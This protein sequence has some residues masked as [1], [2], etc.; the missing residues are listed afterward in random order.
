MASP[1]VDEKVL[2]IKRHPVA[3]GLLG[4]WRRS[5][6]MS[7]LNEQVLF[8][9]FS[10]IAQ[11]LAALVA[12]SAMVAFYVLSQSRAVLWRARDQ[13]VDWSRTTFPG[14]PRGTSHEFRDIFRNRLISP[15]EMQSA[16][17]GL[18]DTVIDPSDKPSYELVLRDI[19]RAI[20]RIR[21]VHRG[22]KLWVSCGA[23]AICLSLL[24]LPFVSLVAQSGWRIFFLIWLTLVLLVALATVIGVAM[25]FI[26]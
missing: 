14:V 23:V 7:F 5:K 22:L 13:L 18:L 20:Y 1:Y 2:E 16:L 9:T 3:A 15:T 6:G 10:T 19:E 11:A 12:L 21:M 26:Q 17:R 25:Q 8:W 4:I 24:S